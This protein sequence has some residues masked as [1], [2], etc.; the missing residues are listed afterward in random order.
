MQ[1]HGYTVPVLL[2]DASAVALNYGISGIPTTVF[3]DRAGIIK[4]IKMG[5]ILS[6]NEL[7]SDMDKIK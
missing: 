4:Y 7:Q 1:S 3:I 2:D 6:L 5:E